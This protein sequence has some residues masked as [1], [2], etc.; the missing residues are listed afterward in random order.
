MFPTTAPCIKS[1]MH[2]N[3][4]PLS[5]YYSLCLLAFTH[6][7]RSAS[8]ACR[9]SNRRLKS[10]L[11]SRR[12]HIIVDVHFTSC[13]TWPNS[14]RHWM[15]ESSHYIS[16]SGIYSKQVAN[17]DLWVVYSTYVWEWTIPNN[18]YTAPV[19]VTMTLMVILIMQIT[20]ITRLW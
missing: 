14:V 17:S 4:S 8:K 19:W 6:L 13:S 3:Y 9:F 7:W 12:R 5:L 1:Q 2:T 20:R 16:L 10:N 11:R 15:A 18:M